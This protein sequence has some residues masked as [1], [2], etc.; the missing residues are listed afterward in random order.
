MLVVEMG[1]ETVF[2][3]PPRPQMNSGSLLLNLSMVSLNIHYI[4]GKTILFRL[5]LTPSRLAQIIPYYAKV[6]WNGCGLP[7]SYTCGG[8]V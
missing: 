5:Y 2:Y 3:P 6:Y 8:L 7:G 4:N 1:E